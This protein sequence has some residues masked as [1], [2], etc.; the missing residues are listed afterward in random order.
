[1]TVCSKSHCCNRS[2]RLYWTRVTPK[3]GLKLIR[4]VSSWSSRESNNVSLGQCFLVDLNG[5]LIT[6]RGS[7]PLETWKIPKV[8]QVK[9]NP[10]KI[11]FV[12]PSSLPS[13]WLI[14]FT[15]NTDRKKITG[16]DNSCVKSTETWRNAN[17]SFNNK[18][19]ARGNKRKK[20][21][22]KAPYQKHRRQ[23]ATRLRVKPIPP[24][25]SLCP[26]RTR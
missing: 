11:L 10:L 5:E 9:F 2:S 25:S 1:M 4:D 18:P 8:R 7:A 3:S 12:P 22:R 17:P 14:F 20:C 21:R 16:T 15:V 13:S 23:Q 6:Q 26:D 19:H 24:V